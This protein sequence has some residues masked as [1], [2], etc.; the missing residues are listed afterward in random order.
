MEKTICINY[1]H[2]PQDK[3]NDLEFLSKLAMKIQHVQRELSVQSAVELFC[4]HEAGH[5]IYW[6]RLGLTTRHVGPT[7]SY[8]ADFGLWRFYPLMTEPSPSPTTLKANYPNLLG[9]AK[10]AA[11]GGRFV[12]SL[13]DANAS[14]DDAGDKDDHFRFHRV[15]TI[16]R[17]NAEKQNRYLC[18]NKDKLWEK[19][20]TAVSDDLQHED[21]RK[22]AQERAKRIMRDW[23]E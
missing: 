19:A 21:F 23:F 22:E 1:T 6:E 15:C 10:G 18:F 11:A 4:I 16:L 5:A 9:I 14:D 8:V 13:V 3:W 2:V 20:Q 17:D 7:I 12:M